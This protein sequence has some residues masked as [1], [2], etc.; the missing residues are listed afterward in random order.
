MIMNSFLF[1]FIASILTGF[2]RKKYNVLRWTIF[3]FILAYLSYMLYTLYGYWDYSEVYNLMKI[4]GTQ[5]SINLKM[6]P[7]GWFFAFFTTVLNGV[8]SIFSI[9]KNRDE[10]SER[11]IAMLWMI[12]SALNIGIFASSDFL[13]LFIFWELMTV[14]S[15]F[16]ISP[17]WTKSFKSVNYYFILSLIG[18]YAM[19]TAIWML[20]ADPMVNTFDIQTSIRQIFIMWELERAKAM[21]IIVLF[22]VAFF[23]KSALMPFHVWPAEAHAEAP[24]DFSAYLSGIMIK[25]GLYGVLLVIVPVL[26]FITHFSDSTAMINGIP[27]FSYIMAW[28][29]A[30]TAVTATFLAINSNDMKR[31][32]AYSTVANVGYAVTGIFILSSMG[33]AGGIFHIVNHAIFKSAIFISLA[34]VKYRTHER[35]MH[36]LGGLAYKM[37]ITFL[38]FLLGIIAAA[39]IPPLNGYAS[40]WM[41]YQSLLS[42]RFPFLTTMIF[43]ASTGAFMYL[44]RALHSVF[45]G[46]LPRKFDDVKEVPF[47][48]QVPMLVIMA[49][50]VAIGIAPGLILK[51]INVV[52][53]SMG[54]S[55]VHVTY[56]D[57]YSL[58]SRVDALTVFLVFCG[59]FAVAF[60]L[61]LIGNKRNHVEPL[62]N[63]TAGQD[64]KEFG[65]TREMYHFA[66]KFYEPFKEMFKPFERINTSAFY[67]SIE[68]GF[69]ETGRSFA[70]LFR[71]SVRNAVLFFIVG[72]AAIIIYGWFV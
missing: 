65:L 60:I 36:R 33:V 46:Q 66:F 69:N 15:Y 4:G 43:I 37:P 9:L 57:M 40:K 27:V 67:D 54:L 42:S 64:P 50:M 45:L 52:I 62:D 71:F 29:G 21:S 7:L 16:I 8:I 30:V 13:T 41:I 58:I 59:S 49:A 63:Y 51:P 24:D 6:T 1:V 68:R 53:S 28:V 34:A 47:I 38:T 5:L 19:L 39:G 18:A 3:T 55:P 70:R 11:G 48:M 35:E 26:S 32:A 14:V 31:L 17:G 61:Y 10:E 72:I 44:F 25:Y 56:F 2:I 12:L 22:I 20:R 23:S